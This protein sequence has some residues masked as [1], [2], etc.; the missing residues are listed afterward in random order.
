MAKLQK[1]DI[2][3]KKM[4]F[5]YEGEKYLVPYFYRPCKEILELNKN[6]EAP[7][8]LYINEIE[9]VEVETGINQDLQKM[10]ERFKNKNRR[11][12]RS[13]N[14]RNK[15][16]PQQ[17]S[18]LKVINLKRKNLSREDSKKQKIRISRRVIQTFQEISQKGNPKNKKRNDIR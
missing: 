9:L 18:R 17:N 13:K 2:F 3:R 12:Q 5:V 8:T 7:E 4:W 16:K 15:N 14:S 11:K 6:G 1:T 10:D